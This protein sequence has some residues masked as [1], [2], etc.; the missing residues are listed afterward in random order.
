M[1]EREGW[2]DQGEKM[3]EEKVKISIMYQSL[4]TSPMRNPVSIVGSGTL[5]RISPNIQIT[6]NG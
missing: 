3:G 2:R 5:I 4:D 6:V 1:R